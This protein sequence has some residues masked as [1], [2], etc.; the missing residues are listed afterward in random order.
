MCASQYISKAILISGAMNSD[1]GSTFNGK[2]TKVDNYTA[3]GISN[4]VLGRRLSYV[5]NL[6][7]PCMVLDT[8]CSS[9]IVA[10][11]QGCLAIHSGE[12]WVWS[13]YLFR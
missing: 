12:Y 6:T 9:G 1:Y 4:T 2:M 3:T 5:F 8:A 13:C 10:I 11:H 7:G